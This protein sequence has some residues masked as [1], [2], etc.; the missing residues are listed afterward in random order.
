MGPVAS[1]LASAANQ[2][3]SYRLCVVVSH[4]KYNDPSAYLLMGPVASFV[5]SSCL[6]FRVR[7]RWVHYLEISI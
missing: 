3:Q 7:D 6:Y 1:F 2:S 5:L 4:S